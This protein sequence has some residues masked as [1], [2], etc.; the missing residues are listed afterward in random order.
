[1]CLWGQPERE[2][3]DL[4][5]D[6]EVSSA[7]A[8]IRC[9]DTEPWGGEKQVSQETHGS[10]GKLLRVSDGQ[11]LQSCVP[12]MMSPGILSGGNAFPVDLMW[13]F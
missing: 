11:R 1:M 12:S 5:G 10:M 2:S 13:G 7:L 9:P 4:K 8:S 3:A 6:E